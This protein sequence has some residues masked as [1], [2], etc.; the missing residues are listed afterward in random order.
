MPDF[1]FGLMVRGAWLYVEVP[2]VD[3]AYARA[4]AHGLSI[5]MPPTDEP[6]GHRRMRLQDP[7]GLMVSLFTESGWGDTL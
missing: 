7:D 2:D 1:R 4:Q 3:A 5:V 6:W